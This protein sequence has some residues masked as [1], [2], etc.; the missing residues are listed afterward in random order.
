M[1]N[2]ENFEIESGESQNITFDFRG[3][4][5]KA[6]NLWK[7]VL[8]CIGSALIIAY[9][10]NIRKPNVYQ[11][12]SLISV[13]N[14]QNP[15]FT[16]NT[17]ISF[18]WGGVS[19]KMGKTMTTIQTRT[20]NEKV[21]D[22]LQFYM[23]Y[24]VEGKYR[25]E[26]IY[27]QAPFLVKLDLSKPQVLYKN[28]GIRFLSATTFEIF[29]N[30]EN[31]RRMAQRFDTKEK[32]RVPVPVGDFSRTFSVGET[33]NLSFFNA[34]IQIVSGRTIKPNTEFYIHF[35]NFDG[36]VNSYKNAIQV[37]PFN[38]SSTS[39]LELSLAGNNKDKIADYLN[40]TSAILS[41]TELERKNLYASNTIKF[42]DSS[43]AAVNLDL[44]DV[45]DEM[46]DFRKKNKVFNVDV[47]MT[48]ISSKL[49]EFEFQK[50][51]EET[52]L[53]Y[54]NSLET[55]LRTKTNYTQ[56]AAP[57]SVGIVEANI[58]R[59]VSKITSLAIERQSLEYT[60]REESEIFKDID[61]QIDAEK[62]VLFE[63]IEATKR[64][65]HAIAAVTVP[66]YTG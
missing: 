42:I 48:D 60:T 25:K 1:S 16:A 66:R 3:F 55:Y 54:L 56:I 26:N 43:L 6:L 31:K 41:R 58:L 64:T 62:N 2:Q 32:Y 10:I 4:L 38:K 24:L 44:K 22:S 19:G 40:A 33:V 59:S 23:D 30:F 7:M 35:N 57:T 36:I 18:N 61:R 17:S 39:V 12:D 53:N 63:T 27:K 28:I 50:E 47:E 9:F 13:E 14:D 46:N 20:H 34:T 8:L 29:V 11:L 49:K 21:V 15:F 5:F 45:T 51:S 65:I 37:A 52:K